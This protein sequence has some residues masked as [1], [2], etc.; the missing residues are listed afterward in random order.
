MSAEIRQLP[1]LDVTVD[2][3]VFSPELDSTDERPFPFLYTITIH[4]RSGVA[5]T[6]KARKWVVTEADGT[7]VVVEGDGVVGQNPRIEPGERFTYNSYHIVGSDSTA[8][9][10]Y[11][12]VLDDGS[13]VC[14]K[15]P[16]F[17]M[18]LP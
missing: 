9:G 13:H 10:C 11:L 1:G 12:A 16:Q 8:Q 4:N 6:I 17:V 2:E 3:V 14:A 15:I 5:V 7:Q 18:K